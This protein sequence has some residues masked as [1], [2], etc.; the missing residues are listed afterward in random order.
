MLKNLY[1]G[2]P[3]AA[4]TTVSDVE[5]ADRGQIISISRAM[6][7]NAADFTFTFVGN[8]D[9][10]ALR[11]LVEQY[12]A[13]LPGDP[14]TAVRKVTEFEPSLLIQEGSRT[15]QESVKM[16]TP[17]TYVA[18]FEVADMPAD[19]RN[20]QIASM[21][22][23]I[24]SRR[25][26]D[27]VREKEGAV[28]SIGASGSM[29]LDAPRNV[30]FQ[31]AFPMKP[32]MKDKVLAIIAE[33]FEE[34]AADIKP[35]ELSRVQEYMIKSYTEGKERNGNWLSALTTWERTGIDT[36][37]DNVAT[38]GSITVDEIKAFVRQVLDKGSYIVVVLEPAE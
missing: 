19:S 14:A 33:Q 15:A 8:V 4:M 6:T 23:Q 26:N 32:E 10:D 7:A 12:I 18:I 36:F 17:Q 35:E 16:E 22:G 25:L 5:R 9:T 27:I 13:S 37:N 3:R 1:G 24:L 2:S 28:Y 21:A 11:P 20:S 38:A 31:T 34:L 30:I 29:T